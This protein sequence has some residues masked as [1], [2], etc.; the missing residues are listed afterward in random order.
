MIFYVHDWSPGAVRGEGMY[1]GVAYGDSVEQAR[2]QA[3]NKYNPL[4]LTPLA[5][6]PVEVPDVK[7]CEL[8]PKRAVLGERFCPTHRGQQLK[9]ME[10]SGYLTPVPDLPWEADE[11][12][13]RHPVRVPSGDGEALDNLINTYERSQER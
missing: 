2:Q 9:E 5:V 11:N 4:G 7:N 1:R 12:D 10:S 13:R 6:R 3:M 8:C